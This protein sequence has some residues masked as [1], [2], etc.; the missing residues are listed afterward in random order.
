M[1]VNI[2]NIDSVKELKAGDKVTIA[3]LEYT[4]SDIRVLSLN[5]GYNG[6]IFNLL[7][8]DYKKDFSERIL[9]YYGFGDFP[10][11][12]NFADVTKL[13]KALVEE[14]VKQGKEVKEKEERNP[15]YK[16]A[17]GDGAIELLKKEGGIDSYGLSC[18]SEGIFYMPYNGGIIEYMYRSFETTENGIPFI[19][20]HGIEVKPEEILNE[21][22]KE[23]LSFVVRPFREKVKSIYKCRVISYD[24]I[25]P[26]NMEY[27]SILLKN[28]DVVPFPDFL[29]GTMYKEMR[30][31]KH[32]TLEDL[33]L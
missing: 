13:V 3:G 11:C 14:A 8:I 20:S 15:I 27:I 2:N 9:G 24:H 16:W 5:S 10:E 26:S 33:G 23:Y 6:E 21:K 32:Y 28:G 7:G 29:P 22:E 25:E 31:N 17:Q 12:Q 19:K 4:V 1:E 18:E 30:L